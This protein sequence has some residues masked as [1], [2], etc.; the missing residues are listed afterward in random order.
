MHVPQRKLRRAC[1][2]LPSAS[3][4]LQ[5]H[6][7]RLSKMLTRYR[8]EIHVAS[9]TASTSKPGH[10]DDDAFDNPHVDVKWTISRRT[11]KCLALWLQKGRIQSRLLSRIFLCPVLST[12]SS[13]AFDDDDFEITS[14]IPRSAAI[15]MDEVNGETRPKQA[16]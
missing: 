13:V 3:C 2:Q 11:A 10:S 14:A 16:K 7:E 5:R 9:E 15:P 4:L 6:S 1:F 8:S 12:C